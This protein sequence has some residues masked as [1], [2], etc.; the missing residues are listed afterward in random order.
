MTRERAYYNSELILLD[1]YIWQNLDNQT[2]EF[3]LEGVQIGI[4]QIYDAHEAELK[5]KDEQIAELEA[6]M[7]NMCATCECARFA[8][9][10]IKPSEMWK[11]HTMLKDNK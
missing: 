5:A 6:K 11:L 10:A 1:Y 9:S 7:Q 8:D 2:K 4:D 3:L